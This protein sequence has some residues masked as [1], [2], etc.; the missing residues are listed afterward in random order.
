[1]SRNPLAPRPAIEP[2][3]RRMHDRVGDEH[4]DGCRKHDAVGDDSA[5]VV[6]RRDR[7]QRRAEDRGDCRV[8]GETE[9]E[10]AAGDQ[11]G[12][13]A[14]D[15]RDSATRSCYCNGGSGPAAR[16]TRPAARCRTTRDWPRTTCMPSL[17]R[18]SSDRS[19]S[20][21]A[22]TFK[23]LPT[24]S[25]GANITAASPRFMSRC[26]FPK[27]AEPVLMDEP[28]GLG[29]PVVPHRSLRHRPASLAPGRPR[30]P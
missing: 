21:A 30:S 24:A 10:R 29:I 18:R 16:A 13:E 14:F 1:M 27:L 4:E 5:L 25:P 3:D 19:G 8:P 26:A 23:K 12:R 11:E 7:D 15:R 22:T 6:G 9:L 2:F 20:R 28:H 17:G